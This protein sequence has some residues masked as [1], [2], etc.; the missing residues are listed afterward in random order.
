MTRALDVASSATVPP[1]TPTAAE[2]RAQLLAELSK[3]GYVQNKPGL[4]DTILNWIQG[5][6]N[7][8][9]AHA[10]GSPAGGPNVGLFVIVLLVLAAIV[11]AFLVFG[12]PRLNRRRRVAGALFGDDDERDS[13]TLRRAAERAAAAGDFGMAIAEAFRAIARGMAERTVLR[14]FPG[15]TAHGF[16]RQAATSFPAASEGL[17][18]AADSFDRVRYLGAEGTEAEWLAIAILER[19]LRNAKPR[20]D[21]ELATT[22]VPQ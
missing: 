6:L 8:L 10:N 15:T 13:V 18:S 21:S 12:V 14:T 3:P 11:V 16:A 22:G 7:G 1:L 17:R 4:G 5:L 20:S 2:A 9:T 19:D